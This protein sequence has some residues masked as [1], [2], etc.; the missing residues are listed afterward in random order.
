M[1]FPTKSTSCRCFPV[2]KC[3]S[4][5]MPERP[6]RAPSIL[7][8]SRPAEGVREIADVYSQRVNRFISVRA[9]RLV[10][11]VYNAR[12]SIVKPAFPLK[13]LALLPRAVDAF[14]FVSAEESTTCCE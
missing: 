8:L 5:P 2:S 14:A 4:E 12:G 9:I 7:C 6:C 3:S 11:H 13:S 1:I 10:C